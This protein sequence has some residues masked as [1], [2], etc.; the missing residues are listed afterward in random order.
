M[1]CSICLLK[2]DE[3]GRLDYRLWPK[4]ISATVLKQARSWL[5][6][7]TKE[8][9]I[10]LERENGVR[11]CSL[12]LLHYCDPIN[13]TIL[14]FMHNWLLGVLEHQLRVLWGLGRDAR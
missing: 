4:R 2:Q 11:F 12:H 5:R 14:G 13:D 1:F 6:Q 9:R 10:K 3:K 8:K 7:P